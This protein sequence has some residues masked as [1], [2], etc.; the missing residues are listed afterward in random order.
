MSWSAAIHLLSEEVKAYT[1]AAHEETN[2]VELK[3]KLYGGKVNII[4][5]KKIKQ[6]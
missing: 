3:K 4:G 6:T 5:A 1:V 2:H